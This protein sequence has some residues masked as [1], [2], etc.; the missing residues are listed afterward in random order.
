MMALFSQE[1]LWN[2]SGMR[3]TEGPR[4]SGFEWQ[5]EQQQICLRTENLS[6]RSQDFLEFPPETIFILVGNQ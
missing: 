4:R 1:K 2:S 5:E 6:I 3:E